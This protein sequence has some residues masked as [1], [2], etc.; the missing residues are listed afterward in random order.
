MMERRVTRAVLLVAMLAFACIS[1]AGQKASTETAKAAT[2]GVRSSAAYAEV[3]LKQAE[4]ESELESLLLDYTDDYPRVKEIRHSLGILKRD[5]ETLGATKPTELGRLTTALG[6]LMVRRMELETEL[7]KLLISYKDE[8]PDVK[9]A[10]KKV[11]IYDRAIKG[12]T[13]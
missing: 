1:A 10:K 5:V 6:K 13:G 11:E 2:D 7:W 4:L 3:V 8:H 12:I 9:R